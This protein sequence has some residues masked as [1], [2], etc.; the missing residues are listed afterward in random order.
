[1]YSREYETLLW[2]PSLKKVFPNKDL[3]R[4]QISDAL[5]S[6]YVARNRVAHHEPL[7]GGR[8]AKT[9]KAI[10]FVRNSLGAKRPIEDTAFKRFSNV[11]FLR[12]Q[13][14]YAAFQES[15]ETLT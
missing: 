3:K 15:W 10:D 4:N 2:K 7:Y 12:L 1:M 8:L 5:E 13:M 9:M 6:I 14:D 11:L